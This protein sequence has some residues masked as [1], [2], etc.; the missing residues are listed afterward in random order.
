MAANLSWLWL[1]GAALLA[2]GG[3]ALVAWALFADRSR[4]RKRC[5]K[6]WYDMSATAGLKCPECGR[7]ARGERGLLATRRRWWWAV[8]GVGMVV[9][10]WLVFKAPE[11]RANGLAVLVP[12]TI[13]IPLLTDVDVEWHAGSFLSWAGKEVSRREQTN[14]LPRWQ[15]AW[16]LSKRVR[17]SGPESLFSTRE[18]WPTGS[19]VT[20][21]FDDGWNGWQDRLLIVRHTK[22]GRVLFSKHFPARGS[23]DVFRLW[24][25]WSDDSQAFTESEALDSFAIDLEW[26]EF[27]VRGDPNS[28]RSMLTRMHATLPIRRVERLDDAIESVELPEFDLEFAQSLKPVLIRSAYDTAL[29]S[30]FDCLMHCDPD[31]VADAQLPDGHGPRDGARPLRALMKHPGIT[32][33]A[34]YDVCHAGR[35]VGTARAWYRW[36]DDPEWP[37]IVPFVATNEVIVIEPVSDE[38]HSASA[39]DGLWTLRIE[40]DQ[41][42][43][44]RDFESK[45]CWSGSFTVPLRVDDSRPSK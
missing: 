43:A 11:I 14:D 33:A 10:A 38:L 18:L 45:K 13:L 37:R 19:L 2:I 12:T 40:S 35:V 32:F 30:D 4:G 31:P 27:A 23:S 26:F 42:F 21:W 7:E 5:A 44:L 6:C 1:I 8:V 41:E 20:F 17:H 34:R 24:S 16:L 29:E 3:I 15:R 28:K 39:D 36:N 9:G 22:T 25:K